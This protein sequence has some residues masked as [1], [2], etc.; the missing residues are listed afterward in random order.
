MLASE[1]TLDEIGVAFTVRNDVPWHSSD[2]GQYV[3]PEDIHFSYTEMTKTLNGW[4]TEYYIPQW[5]NQR[6]DGQQIKWDWAAGTT[7]TWAV[8]ARHAG[9]GVQAEN[10]SFFETEGM[11][12]A[13]TTPL[14]TGPYKITSHKADDVVLLDGV[15]NH[16]R[17][18]PGFEKV[19]ILEVPES[20]TR[21][22]MLVSGDADITMVGTPMIDQVANVPGMQY[23]F[24]KFVRGTGATVHMG[25]NWRIRIDQLT[26]EPTISTYDDTRPWVGTLDDPVE[27]EK[28][29]KVRKAFTVAIDR[30]ALNDS[31]L[32][33]TGCIAY[34]VMIDICSSRHQE[35]WENPFDQD[36][37][38]ELLAEGGYP[39]GFDLTV[40]IPSGDTNET[41]VEV[42][43]AIVNMWGQVGIRA[44]IDGAGYAVRGNEL[45]H[46]RQM[47]DV[48]L[49]D[50]GGPRVNFE[51]WT[52]YIACF[53]TTIEYSCGYD[54]PE[55]Y[56]IHSRLVNE[57]EEEPAW[58]VITE[59][60][61]FVHD[62]YL[63]FSTVFWFDPYVAGPRVNPVSNM[64]ST[65]K[66]FP[67]IESFLPDLDYAW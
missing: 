60:L 11:D 54:F 65:G 34:G 17:M 5:E 53:D 35:R 43:Q 31:I 64:S 14:G 42:G 62:E 26:G 12:T 27:M 21:V 56:D 19:E 28:A 25:G 45:A 18:D 47:N 24:A 3:T 44:S 59:F 39:D 46:G 38:R 7:L 20:T 67:E 6:V 40:W 32:G 63:S 61:D 8:P 48:W 9:S 23:H 49:G 58:G 22:A 13:I 41:F 51:V 2:Y 37:A 52:G 36:Y 15:K 55:A 29:L 57:T 10:L 30:D 66:N 50:W 1:W 33:G 4:I 16:W